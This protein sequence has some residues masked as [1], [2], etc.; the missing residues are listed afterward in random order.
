M[1]DPLHKNPSVW[2]DRGPRGKGRP[3][4]RARLFH[5]DKPGVVVLE[6]SGDGA[7][8]AAKMIVDAQEASTLPP[9]KGG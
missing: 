5:R 6:I 4:L 8:E 3:V 1:I 7:R 9:A 2:I